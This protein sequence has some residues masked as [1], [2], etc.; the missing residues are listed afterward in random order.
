MLHR[1]SFFIIILFLIGCD[2]EIQLPLD[3]NASLLVIDANIT[4]E[5]GPYFVK[6]SKSIDISNTGGVPIVN[7][8]IVIISDNRG[9]RD[10][11]MQNNKGVYQTK[12][13][14]GLYGS[15]YFLEVSVEG[16]KYTAS[17]TMPNKVSLDSL[18]I[19]TFLVNG[20][21]RYSI[22]PVYTDPILLG[23]SYRFIQKINDSLDQTFH[24]FNDNLN[25]GKVNQRPLRASSDSLQ[26]KL[27]DVVSV[28]MQC[29]TRPTYLY[30]Y[31]LN[32]QTGAGPGGG[33]TPSNPPSN[34]VGGALGIFSAHTVERQSIVIK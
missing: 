1:I 11:L 18:R 20:E 5:P 2:K 31:T 4:D 33:T 28:E 27:K 22:I 16:K 19:N 3:P 10:T 12:K 17:S 6:L 14:K 34:I 25:N 30:Y 9:Q 13:I 24:V 23:N 7:N 21:I 26:V 15:T 32:Q 29:I 8:A